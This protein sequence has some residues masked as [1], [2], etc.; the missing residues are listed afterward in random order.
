[1]EIVSKYRPHRSPVCPG[2]PLSKADDNAVSHATNTTHTTHATST[3]HTHRRARILKAFCPLSSECRRWEHPRGNRNAHSFQRDRAAGEGLP[4]REAYM[5]HHSPRLE[6]G[7]SGLSSSSSSSSSSACTNLRARLVAVPFAL[8]LPFPPPRLLLPPPPAP[9]SDTHLALTSRRSDPCGLMCAGVRGQCGS[10]SD[11]HRNTRPRQ[12]TCMPTPR[13][14]TIVL[15]ARASTHAH[16]R[17]GERTPRRRFETLKALLLTD[18][19]E[20]ARG[21]CPM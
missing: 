16:T 17:G 1:M 19:I 10:G 21:P 5:K 7:L 18:K 8:P 6:E 3:T 11:C 12:C 13:G 20:P 9:P 14:V 15:H 4:Q 2:P